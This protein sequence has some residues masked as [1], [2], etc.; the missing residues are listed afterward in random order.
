MALLIHRLIMHGKDM[1]TNNLF[2]QVHCKLAL[3]DH[4]ILWRFCYS[5]GMVVKMSSALDFDSHRTFTGFHFDTNLCSQVHCMLALMDHRVSHCHLGL[6]QGPAYMGGFNRYS[7]QCL[8]GTIACRL[9][10]GRTV[11]FHYLCFHV[12]LRVEERK[13]LTVGNNFSNLVIG[14]IRLMGNYLCIDF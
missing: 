9:L 6:G 2:S 11:K 8:K 5:Q 12:D 1:Q 4:I 3:M 7:T 10:A 14:K 13:S